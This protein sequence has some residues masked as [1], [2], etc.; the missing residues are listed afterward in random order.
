MMTVQELA[1]ILIVVFTVPAAAIAGIR[2][3]RRVQHNKLSAVLDSLGI[4]E[5][6]QQLRETKPTF[7]YAVNSAFMGILIAIAINFVGILILFVIGA[8]LY[9][10]RTWMTPLLVADMVL[11]FVVAGLAG[12]WA[13]KKS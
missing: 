2:E 6:A 8:D 4:K 3:I 5:V 12:F 9:R 11:G 1:G 13:M 7:S 10:Y